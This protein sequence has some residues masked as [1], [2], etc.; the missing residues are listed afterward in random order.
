[1]PAPD[2]DVEVRVIAKV[3]FISVRFDAPRRH[4][5]PR[6]KFT[7]YILPAGVA[8]SHSKPAMWESLEDIARRVGEERFKAEVMEAAGRGAR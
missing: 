2:R 3:E 5:R 8:K 1:M 4:Y 6:V 7:N